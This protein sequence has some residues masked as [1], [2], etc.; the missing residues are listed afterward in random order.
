MTYLFIITLLLLLIFHYDYQKHKQNRL[1]WYIFVLIIF[2]L[3]AGLRYRLGV[4]STRY[5]YGYKL[6]PTLAQLPTYDYESTRY[7][8]GYLFF[9]AIARSISDN[10]V[11]LQLLHAS[12]INSIIFY[13]FYKNTNH[14]FTAL[15]LYFFL[16]YTNYN[17]E[18][19]RESCAIAMFLI[20]WR[21]FLSNRWIKYYICVAI[22]IL[23][24]ISAAIL[25]FLPIFYIPWFRSF[26]SYGWK[27]YLM[28][29]VVL[30]VSKIVSDYFFDWLK[31]LEIS[32]MDE[33]ATT[34]EN[35]SLG[36]AV[37][38][39]IKGQIYYFIKSFLFP[40]C[41]LF[42]FHGSKLMSVEMD[43]SPQVR[44]KLQYMVCWLVYLSMA[45]IFIKLFYRFCNYFLPFYI[46]LLTDVLFSKIKYKKRKVR[47]SYVVWMVI[48][49]PFIYINISDYFRADSGS[50]IPQI[51]RYYPYASVLNPE[52]NKQREQ[53]YRFLST[54]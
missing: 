33:Y 14:I 27:F 36:E 30:V 46:I 45:M 49:V 5:E 40:A 9:N 2:V 54:H 31:L 18:V 7:G 23:F 37:S 12:F 44:L 1:G 38:V 35:S 28:I 24:H 34:Y 42:L 41:A 32:S 6:T 21:Y 47:M 10:F 52:K 16:A 51:R 50:S 43:V 53:L 4:D 19:L 11:M 26:F 48:L 15:L 8:F 20:A 13:F 29:G 22:A 17:Y 25:I 39:N 3:V